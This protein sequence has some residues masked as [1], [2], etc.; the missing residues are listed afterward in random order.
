MSEEII[1]SEELELDDKQGGANRMAKSGVK[2]PNSEKAS[3][4][5][6]AWGDLFRFSKRYLPLIIIAIVFAIG[7]VILQLIGPNKMQEI[8]EEVMTAVGISAATQTP[9]VINIDAIAKTGFLLVGI[10][11]LSFIFNFIQ[12]WI[13]AGVTQNLAKGLRNNISTKINKLPFEFYDKTNI[14]DIMSRITNDVDTVSSTLNQSIVTLISATILFLGSAGFMF[15]TNALMAVVA[16][17]VSLLGFI[18][19]SFIIRASQKYFKRRADL[20]GVIN[21]KIEECYSGQSVINTS[22]AKA[23]TMAEI[24][25]LLKKHYKNTLKSQFFSNTMQ[26]LM[27]FVGNLSW[28]A[29]MIVGAVLAFDDPAKY[30]PIIG[31]FMIYV[32]LFTRPLSDIAQSLQNLQDTAAASERVFEFLGEPEQADESAIIQKVYIKSAGGSSEAEFKIARPD[33]KLL[34][35]DGTKIAVGEL[36]A[37]NALEEIKGE[38]VFKNVK[39]GYDKEKPP[40]IKDFSLNGKAGSK[41]AIVGPTGAGKTTI[42]NLLMKFYNIDGGDI[43]IDGNSI[44]NLKREDIHKLFAMVLQDTWLFNGTVRENLCYNIPRVSD[45]TLYEVCEA[46][47]LTHFIQALPNGLDTV[48]DEQTNVSSGQKQ[49]LTIARAMIKD[50]PFLILDEAT[51]NVDTRTELQI[52][53]A[54]DKLMSGRTSFVIAHRLSTIKNA[55]TILVLKDGNVI[56]SGTHNELLAKKGFYAELY[57]SQFANK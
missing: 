13:M 3:N 1:D 45:E 11:A 34:N 17:G 8:L 31:A 42:V 16:V 24:D 30:I 28:A 35:D 52:Q 51:S 18:G 29:V 14:G 12:N 38:I 57:N 21:G 33:A 39:F 25:E 54:M 20:F 37:T 43:L 6:K 10:F 56:E 50:S 19:I 41:I 46:V 5:K 55:N 53:T 23:Q 32:R 9:L 47:G 40:V 7:S 48:L 22:N 4:A 15:A 26:P 49:L 2:V 36:V 44:S 27:G